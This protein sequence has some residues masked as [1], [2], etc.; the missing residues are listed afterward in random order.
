V[1]PAAVAASLV[2]L[3]GVGA[4]QPGTASERAPGTPR[5][6]VSQF[7][8]LARQRRFA[9]AAAYLDVPAPERARA[10]ELA[11]RFKAVLDRHL[12]LDLEAISANA[13]GNTADDLPALVDEI[14]RI[15]AEGGDAEP[16]RLIRTTSDSG[17]WVF[18]AET[19]G[20]ID[21]WYDRLEQRWLREHLPAWLLV[22][23]P[24]ELLRWQ[25]AALPLI[26]LAAYVAGAL[27]GRLTRPLM[28]RVARGT[29]AAWDDELIAR[30]EG[31]LTLGWAIAVAYLLVPWLGLYAPARE[32]LLGMLRGALLV[33][34][35]WS[36]ARVVDVSGQLLMR[37][38]WG[39][40]HAA[41]R[42]LV[43]IGARTAK[44]LILAMAA[45]ALLSA[46]GYPV[47]SL[48]AG[49]GIGGLAVALAAQKT[50]ENLFGTFSIAADQPFREGDFVKIEDFVGTI[51]T[52]GLR[53][54]KIR[55]LD[56]TLITVPNGR[57]AEMRLETFAARDRIRLHC[58]VGLV[59]ET[60]EEQMRGIL[61]GLERVLR[62]HPKIWPDTVIVRFREFGASS[63]DIEIMAWFMTSDFGE[64]QLYR[65]EVLLGFMGVV[66]QAGSS[67]AFPT[68][69]VHVV[70]GARPAA[71][72]LAGP[73]VE[74]PS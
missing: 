32:F 66:E 28:R 40:T 63:L 16:V 46:L 51:E 30:I 74:K 27:L 25:W 50:V 7:L 45:V 8:D 49:L 47:A 24:K 19:V 21:G 70:D 29:S 13:Q 3:A 48:I 43:A 44:L 57:L 36:L 10:P 6:S 18:T 71:S 39:T 31:P 35:F 55:T 11:R 64:F 20:R 2:L 61:A 34:F 67:F 72:A 1:F 53:S 69:T 62:E 41:S 15:R 58:I 56:R 17:H 33:A 5:E 52:I 38:Q 60:T 12:W 26:V 23:G 4:A 65:Q 42:S 73:E 14:G 54:T 59:Y 68:R 22:P 37:S 9:E